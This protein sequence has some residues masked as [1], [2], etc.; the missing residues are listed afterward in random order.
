MLKKKHITE[1]QEK[2]HNKE[3]PGRTINNK[4]DVLKRHSDAFFLLILLIIN[5]RNGAKMIRM[6]LDCRNLT[7]AISYNVYIHLDKSLLH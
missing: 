3:N 1:K 7:E 2:K 4:V 6:D 5:Y